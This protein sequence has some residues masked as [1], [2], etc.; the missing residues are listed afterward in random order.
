M[1][2]LVLFA[3]ILSG[4]PRARLERAART[5]WATEHEL[6]SLL[7]DPGGAAS[8]LPPPRYECVDTSVDPAFRQCTYAADEDVFV[9]ASIQKSGAWEREKMLDMKQAWLFMGRNGT[10]A[11]VVF[12]DVGANLG[13]YSLYAAAVGIE[14][15]VAFEPLPPNVGLFVASVR[16]NAGFNES[17]TIVGA[18]AGARAESMPMW[19]D[20][21]NRG[22]SSFSSAKIQQIER[23][24]ARQQSV[25]HD[26]RLVPLDAIVHETV[27]VMKI[28]VE[29]HESCVFAGGQHLFGE[30]GVVMIFAEFWR[31]LAPAPTTRRR[32]STS[33]SRSGITSTRRF[34]R[35]RRAARPRSAV[36][37]SQRCS[38]ASASSTS[39]WFASTS[40]TRSFRE[41]ATTTRCRERVIRCTHRSSLRGRREEGRIKTEHPHAATCVHCVFS[42]VP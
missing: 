41:G 4:V 7:V 12:A 25:A 9:S 13:L 27:H 14:R 40:W 23:I 6:A 37:V 5:L 20:Q 32:Y 15:V 39:S 8:R 22:G 34:R 3:V 21:R 2:R 26:C 19:I 38:N 33:C 31:D 28:D 10:I 1:W 16:Q 29:G 35:S 42:L 30:L 36:T 18:G 17:I 11:N 24:A